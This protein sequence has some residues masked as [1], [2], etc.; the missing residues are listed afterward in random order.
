MTSQFMV[1]LLTVFDSF[2]ENVEEV[3]GDEVNVELGEVSLYGD[4]GDCV[5]T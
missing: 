3:Q 1:A 2:R 4:R 5:R